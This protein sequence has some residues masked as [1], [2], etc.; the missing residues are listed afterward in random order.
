[1]RAAQRRIIAGDLP[2]SGSGQRLRNVFLVD[3][4][5]AGSEAVEHDLQL[6]ALAAKE[7]RDQAV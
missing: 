3:P 4:E 1:M 5:G 2:V 7:L 6:A